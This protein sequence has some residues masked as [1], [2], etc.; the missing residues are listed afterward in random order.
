M[1]TA[2]P[3]ETPIKSDYNQL[4]TSGIFFEIIV[5]VKFHPIHLFADFDLT[6]EP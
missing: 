2:V 4:I 5:D 3:K 6:A 1:H